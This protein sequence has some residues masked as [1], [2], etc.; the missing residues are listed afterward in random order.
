M[1]E[2]TP[3]TQPS[4]A[5]KRAKIRRR[6]RL[7]RYR[8]VSLSRYVWMRRAVFVAG[9]L[10][11]GLAAV[12]FA[13]IADRAQDFY[14]AI[15]KFSP[16]LPL[17]MTPVGFAVLAYI[18]ARWFP[19]AAGSG[20]PQVIAARKSSDNAHRKA[21][22]GWQTT[23]AK[24]VMTA[25]ALVI[26]AS[27]GREGPTVQ[28]GA[29]VMFAVATFVGIRSPERARSRRGRCRNC[30]SFQHAHRWHPVCHR[31]ACEGICR[32]DQRYRHRVGRDL[33]R[34]QLA[35]S[36]QLR[37]FRRGFRSDRSNAGMGRSA[38][39]LRYSAAFLAVC[40]ALA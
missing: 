35:H 27:V 36:R 39:L 3:D 14:Y 30:R 21:L 33:R 38:D 24:I 37:L 16:W 23:I 5:M 28:V 15:L 6:L 13:E 9:A 40:S 4:N 8:Y 22:L 2:Q 10:L 19:A 18:T 31:G 25:L 34:R 20:I 11:V 29:S 1:Q 32:A 12:G 17:V 7:R 26:G